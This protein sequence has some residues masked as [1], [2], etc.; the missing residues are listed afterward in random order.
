MALGGGC[1]GPFKPRATLPS[2]YQV[3]RHPL[4]CHTDFP[5]ASQHRLLEE[6]IARRGDLSRQLQIPGSD[7]PIDVYLFD[8]AD[9]FD[10]FLRLYHPEFPARRAF[11]LETDTRLMVYAQWGD[12]VAEDLRHEVTHAYLHA[13][14]PNLPLWLDEGLAEYYEVPRGARGLNQDHLDLLLSRLENRDWTP[15]LARL[16]S[17]PPDGSM[18]LADYAEAWAWV[19]LLLESHPDRRAIVCSYIRD[20][21]EFGWAEPI[22]VRLGQRLAAPQQELT[23]YVVQLGGL[24][25]R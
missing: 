21:R 23:Q 2:G 7:E 24:I 5:L 19:H 10:T 16:E 22:S 3:N 11:F 8:N 20:L 13:V 4:I 9:R 12:R 18:D 1:A 6:L 15:D 14:V 25:R 17:L